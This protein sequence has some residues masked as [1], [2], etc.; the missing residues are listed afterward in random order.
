MISCQDEAARL[1]M[2]VC[3]GSCDCARRERDSST[4][5]PSVAWCG[6]LPKTRSRRARDAGTTEPCRG[7]PFLP[8]VSAR[9]WRRRPQKARRAQQKRRRPARKAGLDV[10][11]GPRGQCWHH[12]V[13][14]T[15]SQDRHHVARFRA[16]ASCTTLSG[17]LCPLKLHSSFQKIVKRGN[18]VAKAKFNGFEVRLKGALKSLGRLSVKG[19]QHDRKQS[20]YADQAGSLPSCSHS[21]DVMPGAD[22]ICCNQAPRRG[23]DLRAV[24]TSG[25]MP[26]WDFKSDAWLLG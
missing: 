12:L 14:K 13:P 9:G 21:A 24:G 5:R 10:S 17:S 20:H 4:S 16:D 2:H 7:H 15:P 25:V 3:C 19:R 11:D 8:R 26:G 1:C 22:R 23:E 6:L 18:K